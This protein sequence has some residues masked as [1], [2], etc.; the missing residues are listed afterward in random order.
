[1]EISNRYLSQPVQNIKQSQAPENFNQTIKR[2]VSSDN[3][4]LLESMLSALDSAV[5]SGNKGLAERLQR[6]INNLGLGSYL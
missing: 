5:S 2:T 6:T 4:A 1:M 3:A